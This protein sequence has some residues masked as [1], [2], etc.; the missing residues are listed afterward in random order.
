[1]L[2]PVDHVI[3][4]R[5][6]RGIRTRVIDQEIPAGWMGLDIGPKTADQFKKALANAK[7][8]LWNGPLGVAE[9]APFDQGSRRIA[10]TVAGLRAT[11]IIGGGDTAAMIH[12]F[13]LEEKMSHVSTG[14][15]A[16]LEYLEGK[17][18]PGIAALAGKIPVMRN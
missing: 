16:S 1:M 14:G 2:L 8:I 9:I 12:Q 17:L 7:T 4:E 6:E 10:E 18:L 13:G 5:L 3:A 11:T 15:G